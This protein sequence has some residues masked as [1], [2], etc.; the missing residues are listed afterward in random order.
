M[1]GIAIALERGPRSMLFKTKHI[2]W[3]FTNKAMAERY[4]LAQMVAHMFLKAT[5]I[6]PAFKRRA[7]IGAG[8]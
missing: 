2:Q 3:K 5:S 1:V 6:S 7:R 4:M 8:E